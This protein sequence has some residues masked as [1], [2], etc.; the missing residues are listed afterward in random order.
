MQRGRDP[1]VAFAEFVE[2]WQKLL[3]EA[4]RPGTT[5]VVEGERDRRSV[6]RL[7]WPGGLAVVHR[8]RTISATAQALV[9]GS[10]RVIVLTDWDSEGG[11]FARR[12]REFLT[13]D[14]VELDLEY[15]RRF[16]R[17][18]RGELVHVEGLFG[19]ARRN[20]ERFGVPFEEIAGGTEAAP[21]P[22]E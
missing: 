16:A 3:A 6:R 5:V 22:T 21:P 11:T 7:G 2:L 14:R 8:G 12:L 1:A 19:W 10:R 20:A 9:D 13:A 4:G 17:I 18:L 15:R